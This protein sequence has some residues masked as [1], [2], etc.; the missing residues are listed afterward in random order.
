MKQDET[1]RRI[2]ELEESHY[3]VLKSIQFVQRHQ[4]RLLREILNL[5]RKIDAVTEKEKR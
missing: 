5:D 4:D 2:N 1:L 3:K